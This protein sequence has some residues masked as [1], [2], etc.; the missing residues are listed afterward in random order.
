MS[1]IVCCLWQFRQETLETTFLVFVL[2]K[3]LQE[4]KTGLKML[5]MRAEI[6]IA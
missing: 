6:F 5:C 2:F 1:A 3:F 4:E